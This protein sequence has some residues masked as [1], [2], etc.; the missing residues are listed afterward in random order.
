MTSTS[1]NPIKIAVLGGGF[2][3]I[4]FSNSFDKF[5]KNNKYSSVHI[6]IIEP[7]DGIFYNVASHRMLVEPEI[8]QHMFIP[9]TNVVNNTRARKQLTQIAKKAKAVYETFVVLEDDSKIEFDVLCVAT[10]ARYADPGKTEIT[11]TKDW[12][13]SAQE[14]AGKVKDAKE[15]LIVGGGIYGCEVAAEVAAKY[16]NEKKVILLHSSD[17]LVREDITP[18]ANK[19]AIEK[20][21]KLGVEVRLNERAE[22]SDELR[23]K[24]FNASR[25]TVSTSSGNKIDSDVQVKNCNSLYPLY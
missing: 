7:K 13:T 18:K 8:A 19:S 15:V 25:M 21:R 17:K 2:A 3:G 12:V 4:Q 24:G 9:T 14:F 16:G 23:S 20:L 22:L 10:G 5:L 11:N 6:T 1:P